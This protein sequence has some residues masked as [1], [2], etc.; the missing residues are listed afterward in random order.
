M[1]CCIKYLVRLNS[2]KWSRRIRRRT[3]FAGVCVLHNLSSSV[4]WWPTRTSVRF[5]WRIPPTYGGPLLMKNS[6]AGGSRTRVQ[7]RNPKAFYT[8][9]RRF[10]LLSGSG[11]RQPNPDPSSWIFA[12]QPEPSAVLSLNDRYP[13]WKTVKERNGLPGYSSSNRLGSND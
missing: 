13:V 1:P 9:I 2:V 11:R 5:L 4:A 8:L 6:G 7:T 10:V 3:S 12:R